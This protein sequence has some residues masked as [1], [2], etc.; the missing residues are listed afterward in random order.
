M[1]PTWTVSP[2][3]RRATSTIGSD[4]STPATVSNISAKAPRC[5]PVA[6]ATSSSEVAAGAFSRARPA[7]N[8]ASSA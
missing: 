8:R 6:Q 1:S 7:T 3:L 5:E 4:S 2:S